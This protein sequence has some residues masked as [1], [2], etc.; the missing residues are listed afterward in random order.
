[1]IHM[2]IIDKDLPN[3]FDRY[4]VIAS[5]EKSKITGRL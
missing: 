1:M 4:D 5:L 2:Q 3:R